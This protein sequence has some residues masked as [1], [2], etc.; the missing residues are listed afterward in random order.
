[1]Q[2][3]PSA[4]L[5]EAFLVTSKNVNDVQRF[6]TAI[7]TDLERLAALVGR[8]LAFDLGFYSHRRFADLCA[9]GVHFVTRTHP[10]ASVTVTATLPVGDPTTPTGDLA[11]ITVQSDEAVT[12]GSVNN[13]ASA[14][15]TG[16]R[17]VTAEVAPTP[18]AQ[19]LHKGTTTYTLLTDRWDLPAAEVVLVYLTRWQIELFFRWLKS[20]VKLTRLLG[21]SENA[22]QLS[23][24]LAICVHL[25]S[26]LAARVLGQAR[27]TP[28]ILVLL[29]QAVATLP[30]PPTRLATPAVQPLL[31]GFDALFYPLLHP[32]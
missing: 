22:V 2:Y 15:V 10:Q 21:Y 6:D 28:A 23:I 7:L 27:R 5:P 3:E 19:R 8:T 14:V 13:R 12:I 30:A 1:M 17:R 26:V 16:L 32:S 9:A 20:H 31:P 11:R 29:R 4:D 25:L 24:W 18:T